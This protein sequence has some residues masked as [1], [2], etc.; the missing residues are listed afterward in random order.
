MNPYKYKGVFPVVFIFILLF[1]GCGEKENTTPEIKGNLAFEQKSYKKAIGLW[2]KAIDKHPDNAVLYAKIGKA[3]FKL[4]DIDQA[5]ESFNHAIKINPEKLDIQKELIK[6][7]MIKGD[8]A[9]ALKKM[10]AFDNFFDKDPDYYIL[11]GDFYMILE[12]FQEAEL[13]YRKAKLMSDGSI[14]A[15]VKLALCLKASEK[16]IEAENIIVKVE[17]DQINGSFNLLLLSDYY[18]LSNNLE[19]AENCILKAINSGQESQIL[20]IRLAQFYL[21]TTMREKAL[22]TLLIL[23][24]KYPDNVR[25]KLMLADFYLSGIQIA[26][27]EKVLNKLKSIIGEDSR[28][29]YNFLMGKCFLYK[30]QIPYAV[31]YLKTATSDQPLLLSARYLLGIAYFAGGQLKLAEKSFIRALML[32]PYHFDT[33]L[34]LSYLHYKN[35]EYDLCLQYLEQVFAIEK[36]NSRAL[37]AKGLCLLELNRYDEAASVFFSAFN[38]DKSVSALY[39]YGLSIEKSGDHQKAA[40]IFEK[41]LEID[42]ALINV[43]IQYSSLLLK[44]GQTDKAV[45]LAEG[46]LKQHQDNSVLYYVAGDIYIKLGQYDIAQTIFEDILKEENPQR[47]VYSRLTALYHLT[48]KESRAVDL[49]KI[50]TMKN[51]LYVQGWI[52]LTNSY[53]KHGQKEIALD[54]MRTAYKKLP[55]SPVIAGNL[56][57]LFL[58]TGIEINMALDLSRKAYEKAPENAAIA[59]TLGWAYYHKGTYSQ[60]EWMFEQAEKL[61]PGQG[62]VKYHKAM[63]F[64]RQ[65]KTSHAKE[66]FENAL[67][68]NNMQNMTVDHIHQVLV[69][70]KTEK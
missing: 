12:N 31:S 17:K 35:R 3:F 56:A 37:T 46:I 26:Q 5:E 40:E 51:P 48:G 14:R 53:L 6:I 9:G 1:S 32:D 38:I 68:C 63:L 50:C 8:N 69:K 65:G 41:I 19:K 44:L 43:L 70:I 39:F 22:K 4:S 29:N 27:A 21:Q 54:T 20:Y 33:L 64:Y 62:I 11:R 57:W 36:T 16:D 66:N 61:A 28:T 49:L 67:K 24:E 2:Q 45:E 55:E 7:L 59:D 52:D 47:N 15:S 30:H 34:I 42:P 23:E 25:F 13:F 18:F 58:E 60:A 10:R